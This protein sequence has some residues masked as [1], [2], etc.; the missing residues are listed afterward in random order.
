M[1]EFEAFYC[2]E[3]GQKSSPIRVKPDGKGIS[4]F[5][6][7]LP[8]FQHT[9]ISNP[10]TGFLYAGG[11]ISALDFHP[12]SK[13][14][15]AL[16]AHR[17]DTTNHDIFKC[18][19]GRA[20]IQ[21][22]SLSLQMEYTH[23]VGVLPHNGNC[24]WDLKWRTMPL[25]LHSSTGESIGTFAAAIGDGTVLVASF[26]DSHLPHMHTLIDAP[27]PPKSVLTLSPQT[28]ILRG[29]KKTH[30]RIPVRVLEW[31]PDGS[32]LI[33]GLV[34]GTV[35][36][37]Q[38]ST[39]DRVWPCWV[40]PVQ[41]S[42]I[43]SIRWL[44]PSRF[45]SVGI[46]GVL[47]IHDIH[48]PVNSYKHMAK[49]F[50]GCHAIDSAD[51]HVAILVTD[52]GK[53][54]LVR[55][56]ATTSPAKR[57]VRTVRLQETSLQAVKSYTYDG[58]TGNPSCHVVYAGGTNGIVHECVFPRSTESKK[59][60]KLKVKPVI[61]EKLWWEFVDD[62]AMFGSGSIKTNALDDKS[63][64]G[65]TPDHGLNLHLGRHDQGAF[66]DSGIMNI[67]S[68][69]N[70][71]EKESVETDTFP[72]APK[73]GE[74]TDKK[75]TTITRISL[76]QDAGLVV[77]GM[78]NG[79]VTWAS[80][81]G[82]ESKQLS[83]SVAKHQEYV[84]AQEGINRKLRC[85]KKRRR[86]H[87]DLPVVNSQNEVAKDDLNDNTSRG[88]KNGQKM[89]EKIIL[90]DAHTV[91]TADS[92]AGSNSGL[93]ES[94]NSIEGNNGLEKSSQR[95]NILVKNSAEEDKS[96]RGV[97][98]RPL[99]KMKKAYLN[100]IT[101]TEIQKRQ[102]YDSNSTDVPKNARSKSEQDEYQQ[103]TN[104]IQ[105][106]NN[107]SELCGQTDGDHI[108]PGDNSHSNA[109][110]GRK[111]IGSTVKINLKGQS[112]DRHVRNDAGV[113]KRERGATRHEMFRGKHPEDIKDASA[114]GMRAE[115][116]GKCPMSKVKMGSEGNAEKVWLKL[117][118]RRK[119]QTKNRISSST[120][121][122]CV[123]TFQHDSTEKHSVHDAEITGYATERE[124]G[125][126]DSVGGQKNRPILLR[127]RVRE[128][129]VGE[130]RLEDRYNDKSGIKQEEVYERFD[131]DAIKQS[132]GPG[133]LTKS[134]ALPLRIHLKRGRSTFEEDKLTSRSTSSGNEK[135]NTAW[136]TSLSGVRKRKKSRV[137]GEESHLN[138]INKEAP[139]IVDPND[140][141]SLNAPRDLTSKKE[142]E[143]E[144]LHTEDIK[145]D[146]SKKG[147]KQRKG[148]RI[149][150]VPIASIETNEENE[151]GD[152][153]DREGI[154]WDEHGEDE[155][156][157]DRT[158]NYRR[159]ARPLRDRRPSWR[160]R[161]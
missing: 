133:N 80:M 43:L 26:E 7:T 46:S 69:K 150:P 64:E 96:E 36:V 66:K 5:I 21:L 91:S 20:H 129:R 83:E 88:T 118:L 37:Y 112:F 4:V 159:M 135:R 138:D 120:T 24:T 74:V 44:C 137:S 41:D 103:I 55:L 142:P 144:M 97:L 42:P 72:K 12:S 48:N 145:S 92:E 157:Y 113:S 121:G 119:V 81:K 75:K 105:E 15:C 86:S 47:D 90:N 67:E 87:R 22:W 70:R 13:F 161:R 123:K 73:S 50:S 38:A 52:C 140:R 136:G 95:E 63:V 27:S 77:I 53:M 128:Q 11:S 127:L 131:N 57:S 100:F 151:S 104:S 146:N 71:V 122:G 14:L 107:N 59:M 40:I 25:Q 110:Q 108:K 49:N 58:D 155:S 98:R 32:R 61:T 85:G 111:S 106:E 68:N 79:I 60:S 65:N 54:H 82:C 99:K 139:E 143:V 141:W 94:R 93:R 76:S 18:C 89:M 147:L 23:C 153:E 152:M 56:D 158:T 39:T 31:S 28:T 16:A 8:L 116:D 45:C 35:E 1:S 160:L 17:H 78:Q 109:G 130:T 148:Q 19:K 154:A 62:G 30:Q 117:R 149:A 134:R 114:S 101:R 29:H 126:L 51:P 6:K 132:Q 124:I 156:E 115:D 125:N 9:I 33:L 84:T 102:S 3:L 34:N 10:T 2:Q